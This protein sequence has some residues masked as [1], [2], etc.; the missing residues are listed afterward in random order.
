VLGYQRP[1]NITGLEHFVWGADT[2]ITNTTADSLR[3]KIVNDAFGNVHIV[4]RED[5]N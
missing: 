1:I 3:P 4:W 5:K 2:R